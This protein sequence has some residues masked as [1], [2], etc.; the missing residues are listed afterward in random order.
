[1]PDIKFNR[2]LEG[3]HVLVVDD[4][5]DSRVLMETM[6]T[7]YGAVVTAVE[8]ATLAHRALT[9]WR[10]DVIVS[11]L[12][13]PE[14]DG[15]SFIRGLRAHPTHAAIHAL[16]VTAYGHRY[17]VQELRAAGFTGVLRKPLSPDGFA[18]AVMAVGAGGR[19]S[20]S[21]Q[22]AAPPAAG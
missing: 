13:M 2:S 14:Q 17:S 18:L 15:V 10:P 12:A 20:A 1:V 19:Q 6:L 3:V 11:D 5:E 7:Y 22:P 16:A 8:S 21:G 4:D 9:H